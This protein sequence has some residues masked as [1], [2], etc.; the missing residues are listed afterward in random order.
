MLGCI[1][2]D[3]LRNQKNSSEGITIMMAVADVLLSKLVF[4]DLRQESES[5][6]IYRNRFDYFMTHA[7]KTKKDIQLS[8]W[9]QI[10]AIPIGFSSNTI[11]EAKEEAKRCTRIMTDNKKKQEEAA[12]LASLIFLGKEGVPKEAIPFFLEAEY[13]LKLTPKKSPLARAILDLISQESFESYLEHNKLA[14]RRSYT[15]L[16][17][18]LGQ[19]FFPLPASLSNATLDLL[20]EDYKRIVL[21]FHKTYDLA[22]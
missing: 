14:K 8:Q 9:T 16:C 1:I 7:K 15:L 19:A 21:S 17:G 13:N 10:A 22:F 5:D 3:N 18:G 4:E 2:G 12:L 20:H 11:D 6:T